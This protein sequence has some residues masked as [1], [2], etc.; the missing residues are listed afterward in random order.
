MRHLS[1]LPISEEVKPQLCV[2]STVVPCDSCRDTDTRGVCDDHSR[3]GHVL[4]N[5]SLSTEIY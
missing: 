3:T 4:P 2:V 1:L 5:M